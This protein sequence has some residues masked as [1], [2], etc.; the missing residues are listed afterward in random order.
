MV[1]TITREELNKN[2][3]L[4]ESLRMAKENRD[5][6]RRKAG[7]QS[8]NLDGMPHGSGVTD[9]TGTLAA[10]IA[11][12]STKIEDLEKEVAANDNRIRE[13]SN[14]LDDVRLQVVIPLRFILCMSWGEV[15]DM[16]GYGVSEET[17]R[18][19]YYKAVK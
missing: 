17:I 18:K 3:A 5:A 10:L 14:S 8:P 12:M 2:L 7:V 4:H 13:F 16:L 19:L 11:D 9:R 1:G 15:A 6:L